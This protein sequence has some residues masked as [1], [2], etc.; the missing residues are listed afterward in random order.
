MCKAYVLLKKKY[1]DKMG[2]VQVHLTKHI[3]MQAGL[4]G[5]S[6]DCASFILCVDK[7]FDLHLKEEE[8]IQLAQKLGADVPACMYDVAVKGLSLIHI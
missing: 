1:G 7:L 5:G 4:A 6:T 8:L 3:P 2:G